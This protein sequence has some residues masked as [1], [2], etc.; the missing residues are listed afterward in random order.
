MLN[1]II[2]WSIDHRFLVIAA[3]VILVVTGLYS[4][5]KLPVDAFPDTTPVQVQIN[6][7]APSLSPEEIEQQISF[8]VEQA[9]SGLPGLTEVRSLSRFGL[10]HVVVIFDD[11]TDLLTARQLVAERLTVVELPEGI[12]SRPMLG[13]IATGL[14]EVFHY[15]IT[16]PTHSLTEL[17]TIQDWTIK[18]Q[19]QSVPGVAEVNSWGG[20]EKQYQVVIDP[21]LLIKHDLAMNEV[22][23]SLRR[24]NSNVGGGMVTQAGQSILIHGIGLVTTPEEIGNIVI[25]A[26][27]GVPIYVRN[28]AEVREG[29]EIRRGAVT[30]NG[31][32]EAVLGLGF[33]LMGENTHEVTS[34]LK[35]RME[36]I[37]QT[38]PEDVEVIIVYDRTELVDHVLATVRTNLMEGALLVIAVLFIFLGNLRAGL[39]VALAIPLSMLFAGNMML[40]V[41]IAG[42]LMSLGAIDF[43]LI[44][45]SSVIMI[46]NGMRRLGENTTGQSRKE[47]VREA[48]IE[49]RKPTMFGELIIM[50]VYLPILTLE[51]IEGKMFTP[52]ALTVIFAL[53]GSLILSL[54]FM[55]AM[56]SLI[57]PRKPIKME[58]LVVRAAKRVYAPV[59]ELV[60]RLRWLVLGLTVIALAAGVYGATRL[61]AVFIPR[62]SEEAI[63]INTVRLAGVSL[64]ESIRY[65]TR[66]E[67]LLLREFPDEIRHIWSRTGSPEVATDPMSIELTDVFMT[68]HPR[69]YWTRAANQAELTEQM[70]NVMAGMP[71]MRTIFAQPIELRVN[72]MIAGIR[73]DLG[74]KL[75]GDDFDTLKSLAHEIEDVVNTIPGSADVVT[76]QLT[77][78]SVLQV[79]LR[80]DQLARFGVPGQEV[81][82]FIAAIGNIPVG[83]IRQGQMR[84]PLTVRLPQKYRDDIEE[85]ANLRIP[86]SAGQRLPLARLAEIELV[87]GPSTINREWSKRRI[88]VQSNVRGRDVG[89]FVN[90][91]RRRIDAEVDLPPGYYV[92]YGGQF[93]HLERASRRLAFV[94]P[95]ALGLI[96]L[97]LYMTYGR[98]ADCFRIFLTLPLAAIGGIAALHL[99]G[100]PFSVSAGVG[101][102]AM[103]GVSVLGDMVFVSYLRSRL[104]QGIPL[105]D[106]IR[107]TALT[108]L[109]PVL[110][111]GLVASLGFVPMALNTSVG[112]EVQ[113]PLATV[114]IGSVITSMFLTLLVLPVMYSL[115]MPAV[116]PKQATESARPQGLQPDA[117]GQTP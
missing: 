78:Q 101:F 7:V 115:L 104:E 61:G 82:D 81:L 58:P 114:V 47:V 75:F 62:L 108:R 14:G 111:T 30:Y 22:T 9:I 84:F 57:L 99:R 117:I 86:T 21:A 18:P 32:G 27:D 91:A 33:M 5:Q 56:A 8:P 66:L 43:G 16:S 49:V 53:A 71:G 93:E 6:T 69:E 74:I 105:M 25:R 20:M 42:S 50:I 79:R 110:M 44:V 28:V 97:L 59:L 85:I 113:R 34:R 100:L 55:P 46:E 107:Q 13:P 1:A 15:I 17:R 106:A 77:G 60:L 102:V 63:V 103:S 80:Q 83:E 52:M 92:R 90:E 68:L 39:I 36:E 98:F 67:E 19:L 76:E 2:N 38:L 10:S 89:S 45:D 40:Q 23:E 12:A 65:G 54:T 41:G 3:S 51:G 11:A 4:L 87:E 48:A 95:L 88:I 24:N 73:S 94:V 64:D 96:F 72:E 31:E 70:E 37:E 35:K 29:H 112:A 109:R 116:K 26:D